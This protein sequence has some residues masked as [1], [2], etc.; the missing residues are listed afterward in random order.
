MPFGP[1]GNEAN[2]STR[3]TGT[4]IL[5][6]DDAG[7]TVLRLR[8]G[9]VGKQNSRDRAKT[10][11]Q[12]V[13]RKYPVYDLGEARAESI[14]VST[15]LI[16]E[17]G[18]A[19]QQLAL[20]TQLI[21][22]GHVILY[23]DGRGRKMYAIGTDFQVEDLEQ[24]GYAITF[25][26]NRVDFDEALPDPEVVVPPPAATT[27][28]NLTVTVDNYSGMA[29]VEWDPVFNA[30]IYHLYIGGVQVGSTSEA[31]TT[32]GPL[33]TG[34]Y[35][36]QV[37]A[38]IGG[39]ESGKSVP[40]V[41]NIQ[42]PTTDP[43]TGGG[44]G[45][46]G[47]PGTT[48]PQNFRAFPTAQN[49]VTL[50]WDP[51]PG[52]TRYQIFEARSPQGV[53]N[54][55][56]T[57]TTNVRGADKPLANGPF[58]Y[59]V[60][61][62]VNGVWSGESNHQ[63][64]TLPY[65]GGDVGGSDPGG[66]GGTPGGG[67]GGAMPAPV[68]VLG[69]KN[70]DA[71]YLHY[72][73]GVGLLSGHKDFY[74]QDLE[75]WS[76]TTASTLKPNYYTVIDAAGKYA[77]AMTVDPAGGRT[78]A[79]TSYPRTEHREMQQ[80]DSGN[81][82]KSNWQIDSGDHDFGGFARI[83]TLP[84]A[85]PG[86]CINQLH[87]QEDDTVMIK[88]MSLSGKIAIV[89]DV[90][91]TRVK[92]LQADYQ[93]GREIYSRI[94]VN[95][96]QLMV[97]YSE[98]TSSTTSASVTTSTT[99]TQTLTN[100]NPPW[101]HKFGCYAQSND[102]TDTTGT[103]CL[104][105]FRDWK[106][107]HTG[108]PAPVT[109]NYAGPGGGGGG[110]TPGAPTVSAGADATVAPGATFSRTAQVTGSGI[111]AQGWR[112]VGSG[113]NTTDQSTAAGKLGWGTPLS[114]S[115]EFNY[116]GAPDSTKWSVYNGPGHSGNGIRSPQRVSVANGIMKL[117]GL[118]GS[119]NTAGVS[120]K[121]NRQYGKTEIRMR[122]FYTADPNAPGDKT[123]GYHPVGILWTD[124]VSWPL[125]G[126]YDFIENGEPGMQAADSFLHYPSLNGTDYK[127]D[128]PNFPVDMR[129][130]HNFAIEWTA[131]S[132]KLY[133]DGNLWYTASG[134]AVG[135]QRKNI[136]E[137]DAGAHLTL[138]LDAF[139]ATGLLGSAME[140]EWARV[141]PVTPIVSNPDISTTPQ[142]N[143]VA[144]TTPGT[145][146]LEFFATNATGTT[147]DQVTVTVSTTPTGGG[148]GETPD[149]GTGGQ[150]AGVGG[151]SAPAGAILATGDTTSARTF[152]SADNGKVFD[153]QGK[154]I[155]RITF[156]SSADNVTVQNYNI[157]SNNQYG[158]VF[159]RSKNCTLQNC[160]IKD[161]KA[162][163]DGDLNAITV[164]GGNNNKILYN[165][166]DNYVTG[167][168]GGSHTDWIQTWVSTSHP[169]APTNYKIIGNRATGPHNPSRS[170][171][172]PSIHQII[173]VEGAGRG[174]NSGGSGN[175]SGWYIADNTFLGSWNQEFKL[176]GGVNF[177]FTRNKM[178]GS[179]S[180]VFDMPSASG[181]KVYSDNQFGS[182]YGSIGA[183]VTSGSGPLTPPN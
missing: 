100:T 117:E 89:L 181:Y 143:W 76:A 84:P 9:G 13:G 15:T 78:S 163:G 104:A 6:P 57:T 46:G 122:S 118:A 75:D 103:K 79:N 102:T 150:T 171:S 56:V 67:D 72:N 85:K 138:Q 12:F 50:Q 127:I 115:D 183:T 112:V 147:T 16:N 54:G 48:V 25:L 96:F 179:S 159:D 3:F 58:D 119:A 53:T 47:T 107:W 180:K 26:L 30:Q 164:W 169:E 111:T 94:R 157:R 136:Q 21:G 34:E 173:M 31:A 69:I 148:G 140:I 5:D 83:M 68:N 10:A 28:T 128:V 170:N 155:G 151:I 108:W 33:N 41:F 39:T 90:Y 73:L 93:L 109:G 82:N 154:K 145:Y 43:G 116:S 153:G 44:G 87:D 23:R 141:Y 24:G 165:T 114:Q 158:V 51:V 60:K 81:A 4:W 134:G 106:Q 174:G 98:S 123:G 177:I 137:M 52:A 7:N 175:A 132:I 80:T 63:Q 99:H 66:G 32:Y 124:N 22:E 142:L 42:R 49:S 113:G 2:A 71:G 14:S 70:G 166:A 126:E 45:G 149:P 65:S 35:S 139:Q 1:W 125:G 77:V 20:L 88:S 131:S 74:L 167:D 161:V 86:I 152:T 91:G 168:P 29:F 110:G 146:N 129:Q 172:I 182:Q 55:I 97:Y 95:N 40:F 17:D 101:Y 133:V 130:F 162:S 105:Y 178:I 144:P 18:D 135:G 11:L 160:D 176:D 120:H 38:T 59:W 156:S 37:S 19:E 121:L 64:F 92:V 61:A 62:E 27:P 36:M 8:Y